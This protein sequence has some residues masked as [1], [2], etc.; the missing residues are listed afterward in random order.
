MGRLAT[1]Q[2]SQNGGSDWQGVNLRSQFQR[3]IRRAGVKPWPRLWVNLRS[4]RDTE[5]SD[6]FPSHGI[7][8]W[9][10][11]SERVAN[12]QTDNARTFRA[13]HQR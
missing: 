6:E 7:N 3:I 13:S 5:L 1:P 8:G 12:E 11:H 4:T 2:H 10:G 9:L